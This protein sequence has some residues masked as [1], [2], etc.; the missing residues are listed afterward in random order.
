MDIFLF[1]FSLSSFF[2]LLSFPAIAIARYHGYTLFS[3]ILY[4]VYM[5]LNKP[6]TEYEMA[7]LR[8]RIL[9]PLSRRF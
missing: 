9:V 2:F 8:I 6:T 5:S 7:F 4:F 1:L 3:C